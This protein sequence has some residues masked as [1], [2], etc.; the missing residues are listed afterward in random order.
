MSLPA[1]SILLVE[2]D[3]EFSLEL[4]TQ[5]SDIYSVSTADNIDSA[6]KQAQRNKFNVVI[7]DNY[8]KGEHGFRNVHKFAQFL[9]DAVIILLS[10]EDNFSDISIGLR[11]GAHDYLKKT[12]DLRLLPK[13]VR[14][15]FVEG[16][17]HR[18]ENAKLKMKELQ[19]TSKLALYTNN[20]RSTDDL[21]GISKFIEQVKDQIRSIHES[22]R[23][24]QRILITGEIGSG[25]S[26]IARTIARPNFPF[27][28]L[29]C[30]TVDSDSNGDIL[31]GS[32]RNN[33]EYAPGLFDRASGGVLY[34]KEVCAL[35]LSL[36]KQLHQ[37]FIEQ[38]YDPINS[39]QSRSSDLVIVTSTSRD[40]AQLVK[41]NTF[42]KDLFYILNNSSMINVPPLRDRKDDISILAQFFLNKESNGSI[43]L[44][45]K[46]IQLLNN[47]DWSGNVAQLEYCIKNSSNIA[48]INSRNEIRD[49]DLKIDHSHSIEIPLPS[50]LDP[51][52][53]TLLKNSIRTVEESF[54]LKLFQLSNGNVSLVEKHTKIS[55]SNIY[56]KI[57]E[58]GI[59]PKSFR[60]K[61]I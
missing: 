56:S 21:V 32:I 26:A 33:G 10:I 19:F 60:K 14:H 27:L 34:L 3:I 52:V 58:Y 17:I 37:I 61:F 36:Q 40:L 2:D 9:P 24:F 49:I 7:L 48:F 57:N 42:N 44:T 12:T 8:L 39:V 54:F 15:H 29:N 13:Q 30:R 41:K 46:A 31:V 51:G 5:L 55:R 1:R 20:Y 6:L 47:H 4:S 45:K 16:L 35:P 50:T 25:K 59:N 38:K 28:E 23:P 43:T 18:I 22:R 11:Q 53:S